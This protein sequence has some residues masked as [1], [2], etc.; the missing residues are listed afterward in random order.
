MNFFE[1]EKGLKEKS[2]FTGYL[3]SNWF[4]L[5]LQVKVTVSPC[6]QNHR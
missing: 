5:R 6:D 2:L 4:E 3:D 1:K